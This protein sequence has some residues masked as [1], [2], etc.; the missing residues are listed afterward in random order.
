[1]IGRVTKKVKTNRVILSLV[2]L[3]LGFL[4]A[5]SYQ[6]TQKDTDKTTMTD[7]QW[8]RNVV[9]RNQLSEQEERNRQL[10]KELHKLQDQLV[11][12]EQDFA[13][14]EEK[15]SSLAKEAENL[16]QYLGKVKV[17]GEGVI[18]TLDDGNYSLESGDINQ[19]IV[20]EHH[21]FKVVNELYIS[22]AEAVAINGQRLTHQSYISCNGPVITVDGNQFPAPFVISAIG[23]PDV[24]E[25]ALNMKGGVKDQLVNDNIIFKIEKSSSIELNP[26]LGDNSSSSQR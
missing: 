19:F 15:L 5:Y 17:K 23:N 22:G 3:I 12:Y 24:L 1:M 25:K 6:I 26:V 2:C 11:Q 16:R 7:S 4:V 21:V 18:V 9:L 13:N 14:E 20:H 8:E 10:T